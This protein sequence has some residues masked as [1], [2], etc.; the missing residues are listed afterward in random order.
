MVLTYGFHL[1]YGGS[2]HIFLQLELQS[3][4]HEVL[5][6]T[7][8]GTRNHHSDVYA[9]NEENMLDWVGRMSEPSQ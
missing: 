8:D 2:F 9:R 3:D 4:E 7:P 1:H 6:L 5:M